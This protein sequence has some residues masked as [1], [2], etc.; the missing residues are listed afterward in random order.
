MTSSENRDRPGMALLIRLG[1]VA[2]LATMSALIKVAGEH[3][4]NLIE[5]LFWRQFV[6]L[7]IILG[8]LLSTAGVSALAT[9]RPWSHAR[10]A[11]F[12]LLGMVLNFG[13]V[14]LLPLAEATTMSF[15]APIWAVILSTLF[16]KESVGIYRWAAVI[17]GFAGVLVIAQPGGGH[18]PLFGAC[19]ALGG[20]FMVAVVSIQIADLNKTERP[21]TI[22]FWF[23]AFSSIITVIA[24]PFVMTRHTPFEWLL[25]MG[26]AVSGTIGQILLTSA[27]RFGK[28][29]SVIVMDYSSLFWATLYGWVIWQTL[30]STSTWIGAPLI[31]IAGIVI[32]WREHYLG[33]IGKRR[34]QVKPGT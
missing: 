17:F 16:L 14:M 29:A 30:P 8:W 6:A 13:G 24:L 18:I 10:R 22:V 26:M 32:A 2:A 21:L 34:V 27:L 33:R 1:A 15:T 9:K 23:A 19:V 20:A 5:I 7:P 11:A 4:I 12:G 3:H 28:V 25:L 31:I